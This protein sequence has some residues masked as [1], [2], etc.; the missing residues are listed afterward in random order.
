MLKCRSHMC[1]CASSVEVGIKIIF[2][3]KALSLSICLSIYLFL[4]QI[5]FLRT[6]FALGILLSRIYTLVY[7]S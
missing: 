4:S 1:H 7:A 6:R 3:E 5:Y 2:N